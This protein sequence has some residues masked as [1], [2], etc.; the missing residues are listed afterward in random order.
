MEL[1]YET[2]KW[3]MIVNIFWCKIIKQRWLFEEFSDLAGEM[4]QNKYISL[5]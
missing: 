1:K 3:N 5:H 4:V 2:T